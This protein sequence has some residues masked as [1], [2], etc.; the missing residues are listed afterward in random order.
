MGDREHEHDAEEKR[1]RAQH[2][3]LFDA[4]LL[5]AARRSG[6]NHGRNPQHKAVYAEA[7]AEKLQAKK[8]YAG[9]AQCRP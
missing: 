3:H 8:D 4:H 1:R 7:P 5:D 6:A 2:S 9:H